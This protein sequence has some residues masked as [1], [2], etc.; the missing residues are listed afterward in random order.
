MSRRVSLRRVQK[1]DSSSSVGG[2]SGGGGAGRALLPSESRAF[3]FLVIHKVEKLRCQ[4][5]VSRKDVLDAA[6]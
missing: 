3:L 1:P 5:Q 2:W 6:G 4:I